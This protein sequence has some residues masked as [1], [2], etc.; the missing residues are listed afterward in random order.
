MLFIFTFPD[1]DEGICWV[2]SPV[3]WSA[4]MWWCELYW[5]CGVSCCDAGLVSQPL[6]TT[7]QHK[8]EYKDRAEPLTT[9]CR[10]HS[11]SQYLCKQK[12]RLNFPPESPRMRA[13]V[14]GGYFPLY[15]SC[16]GPIDARLRYFSPDGE[17]R[18]PP[19]LRERSGFAL[20][21]TSSQQWEF[22][23]KQKTVHLVWNGASS[24]STSVF[25]RLE[26]L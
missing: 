9:V 20:D 5:S 7:E 12:T 17:R 1:E 21:F 13:D 24:E 3:L 23:D 15:A 4:D 16:C 18:R 6:F 8:H 2:L 14:T 25:S 11:I 26:F 22:A 10:P 19:V